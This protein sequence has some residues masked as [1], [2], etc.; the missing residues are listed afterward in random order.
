VTET[1]DV[2]AKKRPP[3][4]YV[5]IGIIAVLIIGGI[6]LFNGRGDGGVEPEATSVAVA[7]VAD[8]TDTSTSTPTDSEPA[9][10]PTITLTPSQ[11]PD[12]VASSVAAIAQTAEAR[13]T[14]SPT[15][16]R[17]VSPTPAATPNTTATFLAN[18]TTEVELVEAH[19]Y[20]N[21]SF[22]TAPVSA[23]FPMYWTLKNSG[24]CPWPVDLQW[25]YVE[26]E[27]FGQSEEPIPLELEAE[28]LADEEIEITV[29]FVAPSNAATFESTWQLVDADGQ[30]FGQPLL[31]EIRT[32]IPATPTSAPTNTPVATPT[33]EVTVSEL[34]YLFEVISCEYQGGDW[35]CH[36]R[37][38]PYGGA[39]G[40][41]S[42]FVFDQPAGQA[43]RLDGPSPLS[44][45]ARARRCANFNSNVRVVDDGVTPALEFNRHL[46]VDPDDH[47]PG[48]CVE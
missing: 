1:A 18:C 36:V 28:V 6:I 27:D 13:P 4:L 29:N 10:S 16:S 21:S 42:V 31:F 39:G 35:S 44:Y 37:I 11:T 8:A 40:P 22:N 20:Q 25:V 30:P 23:N 14:N 48:G 2:P 33:T 24:T 34:N 9:G 15:P 41:Y 38:T 17:T 32:Y 7:V 19:S 46:F 45:F 12:I 3:W 26:G 47:F 5:A 43:T